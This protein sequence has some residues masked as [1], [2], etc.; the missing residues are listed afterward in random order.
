MHFCVEYNVCTVICIVKLL[1]EIRVLRKVGDALQ[2][3]KLI[4]CLLCFHV[5]VSCELTALCR[6]ERLLAS[7]GKYLLSLLACKFVTYSNSLFI[8][9]CF[10]GSQVMS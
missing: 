3:A 1:G 10:F 7:M 6:C 4:A 5:V 9:L 8:F 2:S